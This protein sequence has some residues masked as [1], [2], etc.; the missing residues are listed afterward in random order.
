MTVIGL[1]Q[2]SRA[3]DGCLL[4]ASRVAAAAWGPVVAKLAVEA[5]GR[6]LGRA[7]P[8]ASPAAAHDRGALH[9]DTSGRLRCDPRGLPGDWPCWPAY[10]ALRLAALALWLGLLL[11]LQRLLRAAIDAGLAAADQGTVQFVPRVPLWR[12]AL[13]VLPVLTLLWCASGAATL[14]LAPWIA[15]V[16]LWFAFRLGWFGRPSDAGMARPESQRLH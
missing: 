12:R 5:A 4:D 16:W 9:G 11:P 15:T 7:L 13:G 3:W 10:A 2:S 14:V 6:A 1:T 8:A